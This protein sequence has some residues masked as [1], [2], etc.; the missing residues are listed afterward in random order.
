[1]TADEYLYDTEQTNHG[2]DLSYGMVREPPAPFFP[3]QAP[4]MREHIG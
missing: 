2:R 4:G 1:M 3:H